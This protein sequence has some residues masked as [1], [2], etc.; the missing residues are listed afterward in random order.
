MATQIQ[1][2]EDRK[3]PVI[4]SFLDL[5][6]YKLTMGQFVFKRYKDVPVK[7]GFK[8]RTKVKLADIINEEDLRS[9]LDSVQDLKPTPQELDYLRTIQNNGGKLFGEDYL[10]FLK[11]IKLPNYNLKKRDGNFEIE[12]PGAWSEAIYWKL[13]PYQ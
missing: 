4:T 11:N 7:Y 13:S 5:D 10:Q 2:M 1:D 12:F 9:E 8:N 3:K 6:Q